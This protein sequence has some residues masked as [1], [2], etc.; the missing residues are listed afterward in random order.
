MLSQQ[1]FLLKSAI[2]ALSDD[3]SNTG[4]LIDSLT[5]VVGMI[6]VMT[7]NVDIEDRLT[8]GATGVVKY[9]DYRM[10]RTNRPSI[11]WV[12]F[13]YLRIGRSA[14]QKYRYIYSSTK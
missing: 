5:V 14:R 2:K 13:D 1:T 12:L 4:N 11:I 10:E 7:A 3:C 8:N 9:I 6:V